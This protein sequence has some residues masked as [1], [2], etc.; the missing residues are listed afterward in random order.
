[1]EKKADIW[2]EYSIGTEGRNHPA[3]MKRT[4]ERAGAQSEHTTA[5]TNEIMQKRK[6][7]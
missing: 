4:V 6:T 3:D 2:I 7:P 1:M 5:N